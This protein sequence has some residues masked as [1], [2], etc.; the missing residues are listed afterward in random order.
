MVFAK[1]GLFFESIRFKLLSFFIFFKV[2]PNH[3][4]LAGGAVCVF[5]GLIAGL[6][7]YAVAGFIFLF[8]SL[9][10]AF[11][12]ALARR[13]KEETKFGAFLDSV[14]DRLGEGSLFLGL[15]YYEI[16]NGSQTTAFIVALALFASILVSYV[17]ARGESLALEPHGGIAPRQ[18][19]VPITVAALFLPSILQFAMLLLSILGFITVIQRALKAYKG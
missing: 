17:R 16:L 6:G 10:D 8:G 11:D 5:A 19:R 9:L 12:G 15:L 14:T 13:I 3:L 18:V 2:K 1:I 7:F 4:T